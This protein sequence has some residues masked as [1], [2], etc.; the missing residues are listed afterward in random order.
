MVNHCAKTSSFDPL[1]AVG[2][3]TY[4]GLGLSHDNSKFV[5]CG[6][7][8]FFIRILNIDSLRKITLYHP[9]L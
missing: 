7:G 6:V 9:E 5:T 2:G 4:L 3:I 8:Y 1:G